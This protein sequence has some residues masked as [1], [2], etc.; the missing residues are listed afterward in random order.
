MKSSCLFVKNDDHN[1]SEKNG[2]YNIK[3]KSIFAGMRK[4]EIRTMFIS[5]G[6]IKLNL[7][8]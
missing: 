5:I 8:A 6:K 1:C 4:M 3:A 2:K 7:R